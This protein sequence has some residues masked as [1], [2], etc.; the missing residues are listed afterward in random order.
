MIVAQIYEISEL[1]QDFQNYK[2]NRKKRNE[3]DSTL[4]KLNNLN[5]QL[6]KFLDSYHVI[7]RNINIKI[8]FDL[9]AISENALKTLM[10]SQHEF[11]SHN[12]QT[13]QINSAIDQISN[14]SSVLAGIWSHYLGNRLSPSRDLLEI[15]E[16][17]PEIQKNR[18]QIDGIIASIARYENK[19]PITSSDFDLVEKHFQQLNKL[20]EGHQSLPQ[21]IK[22]F[23]IK[24]RDKNFTVDDLTENIMKWCSEDNR[25]K[26]FLI[27]FST[28]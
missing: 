9:I 2:E 16:K 3:I 4:E 19:L 15:V 6:Q 25:G 20:L 18:D 27:T 13:H 8:S 17:L 5:L 23:L 28:E 12:N 7:I 21:E 10:K 22:E 24:V 1:S 11:N 14:A 26:S